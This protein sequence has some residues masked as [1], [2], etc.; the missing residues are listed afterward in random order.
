[1]RIKLDE[2][3]LNSIKSQIIRKFNL[4][5]EIIKRMNEGSFELYVENLQEQQ[6][7]LMQS[8]TNEIA[9]DKQFCT[10]DQN[11]NVTGFQPH[12]KRLIISQL[13]HELLHAA[14]KGNNISGIKGLNKTNNTG[15]I[16]QI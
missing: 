4:S 11:G 16:H 1:M 6:N 5:P 7:A 8:R 14:S 3:Y 10:F 2:Q 9:I 15:I 12:L 13:G